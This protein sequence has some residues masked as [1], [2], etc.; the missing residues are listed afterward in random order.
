MKDVWTQF[1]EL[2][3]SIEAHWEVYGAPPHYRKTARFLAA[4]GFMA[5]ARPGFRMPGGEP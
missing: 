4:G 1:C 2:W 3:R 5:A